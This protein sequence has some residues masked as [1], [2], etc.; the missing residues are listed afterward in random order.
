MRANGAGTVGAMPMDIVTKRDKEG[1]CIGG[2]DGEQFPQLLDSPLPTPRRS[3]ASA[4]AASV[5]C[6]REAS[7]LRTQVPFS[8]ESS[9]GVPKRSSACVHRAQEI[10]PPPKPPPGRWPPCPARNW[11][12][13]GN[14][15]EASS[16]D[17]DTS[18]S[19]ALDR[20]SSPDQRVGSF[21][22]ITSKRFEDIFLGRVTSFVND[23]SSRHAPAEASLATSSSSSG[24]AQKYWRRRST[25]RDHD[26]QQ[27]TARQSHDHP[28]QVQLLPRIN[29]NGRVEQMSPRACGLMVFF[30][31]SAKP[32]VCGFRSQPP[33]QYAPSPLA[34]ASNNPSP[35]HSR[36]FT[37]LRDAMEEENKTSSSVER[38]LPRPRG[39]KRSREEWQGS[40][41]WGVSSLLG[42]S[43]KYCTDA[44]K[45]LSKLSIGLG[46]DSGN[47]S[48]RVGSRDRERKSSKQDSSSA[49]PARAMAP[50]LTQLKTSRS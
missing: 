35:S 4:D 10:M 33:A 30:P 34:G 50:N 22:R 13:Y 18:F 12:G 20:I 25:R 2:G 27:P 8:W 45:A 1:R 11:C 41:G 40:R 23:R 46:T 21:D 6:R 15:S 32:A 37:T 29:I 14:S 9:P 26:R 28:V 42:A 49:M 5:R 47:S 24:R 3:C 7:P 44:R 16:D 17:D 36:R 43:K 19:D 31:W 38:D 48:P 39:E